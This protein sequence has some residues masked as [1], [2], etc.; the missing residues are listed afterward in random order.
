MQYSVVKGTRLHA[1][2]YGT[3]WKR[4]RFLGAEVEGGGTLLRDKK[5]FEEEIEMIFIWTV[6]VEV[7][8]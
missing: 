5:E 8:W 2:I 6:S 1:T 3:S 4:W 7:M